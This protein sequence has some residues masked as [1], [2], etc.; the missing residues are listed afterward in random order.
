MAIRA[1]EQIASG[2]ASP[3]G[4]PALKEMPGPVVREM[5][6]LTPGAQV[7]LPAPRRVVIDMR[8]G[9]DHAGHALPGQLL[10]VR[11]A[12]PPAPPVAPGPGLGIEPATVREHAEHG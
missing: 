8:S 9:Q 2:I 11:P 6:P 12:S 3:V 1:E 5:A 7:P 10:E 4:D